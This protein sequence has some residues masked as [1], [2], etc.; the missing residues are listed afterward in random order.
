MLLL[1]FSSEFEIA[2][3]KSSAQKEH[4]HPHEHVYS[5]INKR[6]HVEQTTSQSTDTLG[7][8]DKEKKKK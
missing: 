3:N 5:T 1:P 7:D 4:T 8:R 2:A 6:L